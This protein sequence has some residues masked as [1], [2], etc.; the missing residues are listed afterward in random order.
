MA[1]CTYPFLVSHCIR[2]RPCKSLRQCIS[3]ILCHA[4]FPLPNLRDTHLH[5]RNTWF[6]C[7]SSCYL[8]TLLHTMP[9]TDI[10]L[11]IFFHSVV[12]FSTVLQRK[13][14][15]A[16]GILQSHVLYCPSISKSVHLLPHNTWFRVHVSFCLFVRPHIH[17]HLDKSSYTGR[18]S[19]SLL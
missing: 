7:L 11:R 19:F 8:T 10:A 18:V 17:L 13:F 4:S 9:H 6:L 1:I 15:I 2:I 14:R 12:H 3:L 16:I 5:F